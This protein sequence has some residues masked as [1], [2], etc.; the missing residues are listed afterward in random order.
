MFGK[1][2]FGK[3][4]GKFFSFLLPVEANFF[5]LDVT[6]HPVEAHD[7]CFGAIL[8][9]ADSADSVG[10]FVVIFDLSGR[11]RMAYFN[12]GRADGNSLLAFEEDRTGFSLG[13]GCHDGADR[14]SLCEDRDVWSW[15]RPDWRRR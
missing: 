9:H 13:G 2:V 8:A 10:G 1:E 7:K 6:L 14:L 5:P 12:Q 11:L 3:V 4:I 15:S